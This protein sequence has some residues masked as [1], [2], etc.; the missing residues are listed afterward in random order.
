MSILLNF[1]G[2]L[3]GGTFG[4]LDSLIDRGIPYIPEYLRGREQQYRER[5]ADKEK[6]Q[7]KLFLVIGGLVLAVVAVAVA[8]RN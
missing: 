1:L 2:K 7:L 6:E 8:R 4:F 3:V 5:S